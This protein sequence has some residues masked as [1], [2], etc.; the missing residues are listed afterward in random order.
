M[1]KLAQLIAQE[2]GFNVPGSVPQRDNNPGD[3]R[4]SPHSAHAP[5][6]PDGIGQI[7]NVADGW[8][9]LER[10]LQL[11]ADRGLTLE[12]AIYEF[13]PPNENN[14]AQYLDFVCNG[15]GCTPDTLVAD[16]LLIT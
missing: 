8:S 12:Q 14:S 5:G 10:Q 2:E 16:A 13:A 7:D 15:L 4:H 6:D 9:D 1:T 11:Y 3:L